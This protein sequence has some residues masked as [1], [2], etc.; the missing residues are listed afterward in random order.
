MEAMPRPRPPHLHRQV[1]RHGKS[2]WYVRVG[3]GRR[4]RIRAAFGTPEFDAEY[5]AAITARPRPSSSSAPADTLAWLI[6]RYRETPAWLDLS[7]STRRQREALLTHIIKSAGKQPYAQITRATI[8][9][10]RDRRHGTPAQA[11]HFLDTMRDSFGG[12]RMRSSPKQ[13][14]L[15]ALPIRRDVRTPAFLY[16]PRSKSPHMSSAG[17]WEHGSGCGLMFC[18]IQVFGVA[19]R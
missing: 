5:H 12:L 19:T 8:V 2:V 18:Y 16:G 4:T 7:L 9:A 17:R 10:G 6:E 15:P 14:L 1:T 3:K 13:I 11:R